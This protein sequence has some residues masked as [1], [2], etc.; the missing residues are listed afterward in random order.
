MSSSPRFRNVANLHFGSPS[1]SATP[2]DED[3]E[4]DED[5]VSIPWRSRPQQ[6]K[7]KIKGTTHPGA[8]SSSSNDEARTGKERKPKRRGRKKL[9]KKSTK[10]FEN[11]LLQSTEKKGL[12]T[13]VR[14]KMRRKR[15]R[16]EK[17]KKFSNVAAARDED[18]E[19]SEGGRP[20]KGRKK[21]NLEIWSDSEPTS[22]MKRVKAVPER[23]TPKYAKRKAAPSVFKDV[24]SDEEAFFITSSEEEEEE[25]DDDDDESSEDFGDDMC[26]DLDGSEKQ[27]KKKKK[28]STNEKNKGEET[29]EEMRVEEEYKIEKLLGCRKAQSSLEN[30]V[31]SDNGM[32]FLVKWCYYSYRDVSWMF[33]SK[34]NAMGMSKK[35]HGYKR[36]FGGMPS[37]DPDN[38]FPREYLEIERIFATK[39]SEEWVEYGDDDDD[40]KKKSK[41]KVEMVRYYYCKWKGL[42]YSSATWEPES[43]LTSEDDLKEIA[44]FKAY[45][46]PSPPD[47]SLMQ[48]ECEHL[49]NTR[50]KFKDT[51]GSL[52]PTIPEFKNGMRLREYQESSFRW[53]VT[54][55]Y[56]KKNVILG[57]EMGLGKTAQTIAVLEYARRYKYK[58]R[59]SFCVVAPLSTLTHWR[60]EIEKWTDMNAIIF[61]GNVDD[62]DKC[63]K[64]EFWLNKETGEVKFDILLISYE[65]I[66]GH[67]E[68]ILSDFTFEAL[69]VDEGHRL[70]NIKSATTQSILSMQYDWLLMLTGTPIQ[71]NIKELF[72]LMHVLSPE[73]YPDWETF[74]KEFGLDPVNAGNI[75]HQPTAEQVISIREVLKPR[76]LRRLKDDVEKIPAKE[77]IV[78]KV[79]LSAQQRG[80]YIAIAEKNVGVL[81]EG[82]KTKNT[83]QL[84]NLCME[85]RKV[86]NHP[87]L[88]DGLENDYV[89]R[90]RSALREGEEMPSQLE[91]LTQS[92]GKMNFLGKLLSKLKDDGS[93]VL[94]FSQFKRVLDILQDYLFLLR[95]PCE[96][97]DGGTAVQKR[98]DGIDRFNDPEQDS[99]AFLLSTRAGGV[100]IT[101]T[102]ADTAIIFDSD[103]NPQNDLQ[104]MAR[105]HRIGQTKEVKVYRLITNGTYEYELFQSASRKA[106]LDEVLIGGGGDMSD[107]EEHG[108]SG[109]YNE[110]GENERVNGGKNKK[111][112]KNEAER[113]TVL[114]QKGLQFARMGEQAN[115]ESKK[116]EDEDID[117]ILSKRADVKAIGPKKGNAFS[118]FTFDAREE[119]DKEKFGN[120]DP[121]EYW[122]TMFPDAAR[123]AE[124]DKKARKFVDERLIVY[125]RRNRVNNFGTNLNLS[126]LE[127]EQTRGRRMN[128]GGDFD[129]IPSREKRRD[130]RNKNCWS[131]R[132]V[133]TVYDA[134]FTYGCPYEDTRRVILSR[135]VQEIAAAGRSEQEIKAVTRSLL[136]IF[137]VLRKDG[138]ITAQTL[139]NMD[140]L[141][142]DV[143][144][145]MESM[146]VDVKKAFENRC[147][148]LVERK[149]LA[150]LF[151]KT[152]ADEDYVWKPDE[153]PTLKDKGEINDTSF[154]KAQPWYDGCRSTFTGWTVKHDLVLLRGSLEVGYS[155]WNNTKC[156][157]QLESLFYEKQFGSIFY[158]NTSPPPPPHDSLDLNKFKDIAKWRLRGLLSRMCGGTNAKSGHTSG[159][160][161]MAIGKLQW[162]D[163]L[164]EKF[165]S[166]VEHLMNTNQRIA[167]NAIF[168]LMGES[169][170]TSRH[171]ASYLQRVRKGSNPELL[172]LSV[173]LNKYE[174]RFSGGFMYRGA[175]HIGSNV[176]QQQQ[177]FS[178]GFIYRG[179]YYMPGSK[180]QQQQQ[181]QQQERVL[182]SEEKIQEQSLFFCGERKPYREVKRE[183]EEEN[184]EN[185]VPALARGGGCVN[186]DSI[187][188]EEVEEEKYEERNEPEIVELI[189]D[190]D[191]EE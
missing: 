81:L 142:T 125:G 51:T 117:T 123:K 150:D 164:K 133:K 181:E 91:L 58:Y 24:S 136:G 140:S 131:Q 105:C 59:P 80:Y 155:P 173:R 119:E 127:S 98:Q 157:E 89:E 19:A 112:K 60:R 61:N 43:N 156:K 148:R 145:R 171:V 18:E 116:F 174:E 65:G 141:F 42:N 74:V 176:Q 126:L 9:Q 77:E 53:M 25:E 178:G 47:N 72:G 96:R 93:K 84:K 139:A 28:K 64:Y 39:E 166:A 21:I 48:K 163:V 121:A 20:R 8:T 57:D 90:R 165:C 99:F 41:T 101:L 87:F 94:I 17:Q 36:K 50:D 63:E 144:P 180:V 104:A 76:M 46:N 67:G 111:S 10:E 120:V 85:L 31:V 16:L 69:V 185:E 187:P 26:H 118:T 38:L 37:V 11:M 15:E 83:P 158:E 186:E 27:R 109:Y 132:E 154:L 45:S 62:R 3:V 54:N 134:I 49:L 128:K 110:Y 130:G 151:E 71:N 182:S 4:G 34:L 107:E 1:S 56:K 138:S 168:D 108:N 137:D 97:L 106:A 115:E 153:V 6:N 23:S 102:A 79:E 161:S 189:S 147:D 22:A 122:K 146:F 184:E 44:R 183:E 29:E 88:C 149:H 190:D 7:R 179:Q 159:G 66:R 78:V 35:V 70:K 92:S 68:T 177:E 114:L 75:N 52:D 162:T 175:Y 172:E 86:C 160:I 103:W 170:L 152:R 188:K 82:T 32:D 13:S 129:Y 55:F 124:E 191:S 33:E 143:F 167:P 30:G 40:Q 95:L 12:G 73:A 14:E 135:E 169:D 100:G 2:L 113:I 5:F